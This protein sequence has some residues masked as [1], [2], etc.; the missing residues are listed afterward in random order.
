MRT[1]RELLAAYCQ[2]RDQDAFRL[3]IDRYIR[4][5]FSACLR[6]LRDRH[7]AEDATQGVFL[8]VAEKA[9]TLK[10][11]RLAG[12]LLT[13]SRYACANIRRER[14]RR[15]RRELMAAEEHATTVPA[16]T[17]PDPLADTLDEALLALAAAD[18]EA[19]IL[20]YMQDQPF[21][22][23]ATAIGTSEEAARKRA[24]R[25]LEKLRKFFARRGIHT[26]IAAIGTLLA[27]ENAR[28]GVTDAMTTGILEACRSAATGSGAA[29]SIAKGTKMMMTMAKCK[30]A[31][32]LAAAA[33]LVGAGTWMMTAAKAEPDK[34]TAITTP[35]TTPVE[36]VKLDLTTPRNTM[37]SFCKA[38]AAGQKEPTF[39]ALAIDTKRPMTEMDAALLWT[40]AQNRMMK[41][42]TKAFGVQAKQLRYMS[43]TI[44]EAAAMLAGG[45]EVDSEKGDTA[46]LRIEV[47]EMILKAVDADMADVLR[48]WSNQPIKFKKIGT[49]WRYDIDG[50]M[51][52]AFTLEDRTGG[53]FQ[54]KPDESAS[55]LAG[56]ADVMDELD[57]E[58]L[59]GQ[60]DTAGAAA[61]AQRRKLDALYKQHNAKGISFDILPANPKPT[62]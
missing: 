19:V 7:L 36:Q 15:Q 40:L 62:P 61:T 11:D 44:D 47:P 41:D 37:A 5:V 34:K 4:L 51:K 58:I 13:V 29:F 52:I 21:K 33:M 39:A 24:D 10:Q 42:A 32:A 14:A 59:D 2:N 8:I 56:I 6:Q 49:E 22:Q 48:T 1:D 55:V 31:A 27:A 12:W 9:A 53:L 43:I 46:E 25:G 16:T 54:P 38:L 45:T 26:S 3:F 18:R 17:S 60:Y 20:R 23:V 30:I 35:A 57:K 28:A 50:S